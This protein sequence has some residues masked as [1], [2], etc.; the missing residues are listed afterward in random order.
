MT[1]TN[2]EIRTLAL[3]NKYVQPLSCFN[4]VCSIVDMMDVSGWVGDYFVASSSQESGQYLGELDSTFEAQDLQ[5]LLYLHKALSEHEPWILHI[6][7][8]NIDYELE[9]YG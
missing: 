7:C 9:M 3:S 8:Y 6:T 1:L 4:A 5:D 2:N